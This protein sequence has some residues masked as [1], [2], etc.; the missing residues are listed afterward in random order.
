MGETRQ[1]RRMRQGRESVSAAR[2]DR[3]K[4]TAAEEAIDVPAKAEGDHEVP[5]PAD[6]AP[7][8][9]AVSEFTTPVAEEQEDRHEVRTD[10]M[11]TE[12]G[13]PVRFIGD[14]A[15][16]EMKK[17]VDPYFHHL[18]YGAIW[19]SARPMTAEEVWKAPIV[20]MSI[21]GKHPFVPRDASP[22][23][24]EALCRL[25]AETGWVVRSS[26][27]AERYEA[28]RPKPIIREGEAFAEILALVDESAYGRALR[29][30]ITEI[31]FRVNRQVDPRS[32][33]AA[34]A[35]AEVDKSWPAL[36]TRDAKGTGP[37]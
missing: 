35:L 14:K 3:E 18:V 25:L 5:A 11:Y 9:A 4:R 27:G 37:R 33:R 1:E 17:A 8:P 26:D 12:V 6:T 32:P 30:R 29:P 34:V 7:P 23:K 13:G 31:L 36:P 15:T 22:S 24:I 10:A 2:S 20:Q 28:V 16:R 19:N 21:E